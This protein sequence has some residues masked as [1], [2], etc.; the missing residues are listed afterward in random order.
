M[1]TNRKTMTSQTQVIITAENWKKGYSI[2]QS[3]LGTFPSGAELT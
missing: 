1:G 2:I 3:H